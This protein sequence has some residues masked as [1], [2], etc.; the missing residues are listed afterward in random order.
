MFGAH[1]SA[2]LAMEHAGQRIAKLVREAERDRLVRQARE[3]RRR[4]RR[5]LELRAGCG[6]T[7]KRPTAADCL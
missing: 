3:A 4:R 6:P 5:G 2:E 7:L 1:L